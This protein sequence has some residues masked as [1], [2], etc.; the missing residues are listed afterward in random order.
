[1]RKQGF[2]GP[3]LDLNPR[4]E[5]PFRWKEYLNGSIGLQGRETA[6]H[7]N[8]TDLLLPATTPTPGSSVRADAGADTARKES[9]PRALRGVRD[10]RHAISRV[11]DIG[12]EHVQKLKHT[13][14]P[15]VDYLY[16]PDVNQDDLP[17]YDFV[18]RSTAGTSS[19]TGSRAVCSPSSTV[20]RRSTRD[21]RCPRRSQFVQRCDALAV[22]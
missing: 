6:Y 15:E 7:M 14:E 20:P 11:F 16:I 12:G 10:A 22:R 21:G 5:V 17:T 8:N 9:D 19:P 13:I 4:A 1:M 18:D 2:D 3:R